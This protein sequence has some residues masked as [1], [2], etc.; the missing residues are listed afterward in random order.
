VCNALARA[1][2][3]QNVAFCWPLG[4]LRLVWLVR[5]VPRI[6]CPF[7]AYPS[8][9]YLPLDGQELEVLLSQT[10]NDLHNYLEEG[11]RAWY[12]RFNTEEDILDNA[13]FEEGAEGDGVQP[14]GAVVPVSC[15]P[16]VLSLKKKSAGS[17]AAEKARPPA[18]APTS[19][20]ATKD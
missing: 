15:S 11:L 3:V 1:K 14:V 20:D 6:A 18:A 19:A 2:A 8:F 5:V 16:A 4:P 7:V 17:E 9:F 12:A 10:Y 13:N